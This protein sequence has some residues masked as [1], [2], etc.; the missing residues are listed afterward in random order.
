MDERRPDHPDDTIIAPAP[1]GDITPEDRAAFMAR[2]FKKSVDKGLEPD[3]RGE[4]LLREAE[5]A[6]REKGQ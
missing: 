4:D 6:A 3:T 1:G 2:V 5:I